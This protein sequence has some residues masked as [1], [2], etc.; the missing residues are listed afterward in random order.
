MLE[1]A[2]LKQFLV[3]D[4]QYSLGFNCCRSVSSL[5]QEPALFQM[6][7]VLLWLLPLLRLPSTAASIHAASPA[8]TAVSGMLR[9]SLP[10]KHLL[11]AEEGASERDVEL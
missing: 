4:A 6:H 5:L 2:G 11:P 1:G 10:Y 9:F 8:I 3:S 7:L